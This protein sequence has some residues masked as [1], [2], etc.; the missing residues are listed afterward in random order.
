MDRFFFVL[1]LIEVKTDISLKFTS[2]K[3]LLFFFL[4]C[5]TLSSYCQIPM[6]IN[7]DLTSRTVFHEFS[8]PNDTR[9]GTLS[10]TVRNFDMYKTATGQFYINYQDSKNIWRKKYLGI[11]FGVHT[12][13]GS[14]IFFSP[15]T[16]HCWI[17]GID[18][19]GSPTLKMA[20]PDALA[21]YPV[22]KLK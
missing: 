17:W 7:Y 9:V 15:D 21:G 16:M 18:K 13:E 10:V 22:R 8:C 5:F 20:L 19:Y 2:V 4:I 11:A 3:I 1:F 12:Y 6:A 14:T